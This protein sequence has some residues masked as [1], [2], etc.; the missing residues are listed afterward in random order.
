MALIAVEDFTPTGWAPGI[1]PGQRSRQ[2]CQQLETGHILFFARTPFTLPEADLLFLRTVRQAS[3]AYHKNIAYRPLQD[4][5]TGF[6]DGKAEGD[7]LRAVFRTYSR[8]VI[9]FV[10]TFL[11]PYAP[12]WRIDY[13]SFR[14]LEESTRV[15]PPKKRNDLL[16]VD[17]FPTRPTHGRCILRVFTNIHPDRPRRWMTGPPFEVIVERWVPPAMLGRLT[18]WARSPV[19]RFGRRVLA[20][21]RRLGLPV[22]VRPPYDRFM[23]WLHDYLKTSPAFQTECPK[24]HWEFPPGS[25]W[26]CFTDIVPHAVLGGQYALEQTFLIDPAAFQRPEQAPVRILERRCGVRLAGSDSG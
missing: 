5:V 16:H 6:A 3:S 25:T 10:A 24:E 4:R 8:A 11:A 14:P 15:L 18:R 26:M 9:D 17:A 22:V 2:Y 12:T 20:G 1:D 13:A 23:L 7:R 19:R 21:L